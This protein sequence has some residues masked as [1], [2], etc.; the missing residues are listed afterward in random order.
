MTSP[1]NARCHTESAPR[2]K[3]RP[4]GRSLANAW[5]RVESAVREYERAHH[6]FRDR[7]ESLLQDAFTDLAV[8]LKDSLPD[9][10]TR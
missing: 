3:E 10:V 4:W 2:K 7:E 9:E 1:S 6:G 5:N 8:L